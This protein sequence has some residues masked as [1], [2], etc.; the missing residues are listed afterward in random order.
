MGSPAQWHASPRRG[1]APHADATTGE[2]RIPLSLFC[3]DEHKGDVDLVLSRVEGE[4]LLEEL[5][6]GL[7]AAV[8]NSTVPLRSAPEVVR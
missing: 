2:V 1:A 6:A 5:R 8:A 4:I 3:I 7:T